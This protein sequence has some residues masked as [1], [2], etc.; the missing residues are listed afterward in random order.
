MYVLSLQSCEVNKQIHLLTILCRMIFLNTRSL[1]SLKIPRF[2]M[3]LLACYALKRQNDAQSH[4]ILN[5]D[6]FSR[7]PHVLYIT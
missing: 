6:F 3:P 1:N 5:I 4:G 2:E 7:F